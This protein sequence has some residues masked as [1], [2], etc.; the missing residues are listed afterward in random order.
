[1][2]VSSTLLSLAFTFGAQMID[3]APV[4]GWVL[5]FD[6]DNDATIAAGTETTAGPQITD[7]HRTSPAANFP[8][9]TLGDGDSITLTGTVSFSVTLSDG[10]F[11]FGLFDGDNPVTEGSGG[12]GYVGLFA[13]APIPGGTADVNSANG[14]STS[15]PF[16]NAGSDA[17]GSM[18]DPGSTPSANTPLD[19]TLILTRSGASVDIEATITDGGPYTST[20]TLTGQ[21]AFPANFT[22]NSVAFLTGGGFAEPMTATYSN[23][24]VS[25]NGGSNPDTDGDGID[26]AFEQII[27][28][29]N[30]VDAVDGLDD[31]MGTGAAPAVTDFDEDGADDGEEFAEKTDPLNEDSDED[32]FHDGAETNDG[33]FNSYD[34]VTNRGDT[35]T[36]PMDP[37][38]DGDGLD[39][40][41][42][43]GSGT[44][45][46][47]DMT[48][49]DPLDPDSDG[50]NTSDGA[51]VDNGTDPNDPESNSGGRLLGIDFNRNDA[52][53]SPSQSLFRIISGSQTQSANA[54]SYVKTVGAHQVTVSEP[55]GSNLEFRGG[56]TDGTRAIPGGDTSLSFLVADFVGTSKRAIHISI[57]NLPAGTYSFRS[58]HLEP[59]T[60][61]S[62]GFAQGS[63]TTTP[64]LIEARHGGVVKDTVEPTALG[65]SGLNTTFIN[66]GQIPTIEFPLVHDGSPLLTIELRSTLP[67]TGDSFLFLNGFELFQANP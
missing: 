12:N 19:F 4:T 29:A 3:A 39:D 50:D 14:G 64:N 37:D 51:E 5:L 28:D 55:G 49:T 61:T 54:P 16:E 13:E 23:I 56:N 40:G 32:G 18:S 9:V 2:R 43:N 38:T 31:V 22:Y 34:Y 65:S 17:R 21:T 6:G 63:T 8:A 67:G 57:S 7:A 1:M 42:E 41:V 25:T 52:L 44:F 15:H 66:D 48:G 59:S 45:V 53:S 26:D 27:I 62:L 30:P 47:A 10:Q 35:G 60:G 24:D 36:D 33:T 11:R 58:W 20:G 46:N